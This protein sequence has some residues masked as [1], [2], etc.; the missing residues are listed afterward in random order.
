MNQKWSEEEKNS[1]SYCR[2]RWPLLRM[3]GP[4]LLF[5]IQARRLR[6]AMI[7]DAKAKSNNAPG[8]GT[9]LNEPLVNKLKLVRTTR[10]DP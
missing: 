7:V 9:E 10:F 4:N 8:S 6:V 3:A 1:S 5:Q 2:T